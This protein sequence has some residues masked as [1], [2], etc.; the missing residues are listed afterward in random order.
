MVKTVN[1]AFRVFLD[2]V[3]NLDSEKTKT[4]RSSRDNL[5]SNINSFSGDGDFDAIKINGDKYTVIGEL[6]AQGTSMGNNIECIIRIGYILKEK[7]L[8]LRC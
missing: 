6:T 5:I 4:A 7:S 3:V 2:D 1:Q 8:K